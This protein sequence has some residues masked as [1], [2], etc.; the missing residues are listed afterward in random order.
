MRIIHLLPENSKFDAQTVRSAEAANCGENRF[1]RRGRKGRLKRGFCRLLGL[2][3]VGGYFDS[4]RQ[5]RDDLAWCQAIFIHWL[6]PKTVRELREL[7]DD[8]VIIW[9]CW[10]ADHY[11][12]VGNQAA[13]YLPDT[14]RLVD[15]LGERKWWRKSIGKIAKSQRGER[16][17][18][19][20]IEKGSATAD[21]LPGWFR[22]FAPRID[23]FCSILPEPPFTTRL[24]GYSAR[25]LREFPYYSEKDTLMPGPPRMAGEDVLLGNSADPSNNH[26]DAIDLLREIGIGDGKLVVPLNYGR[27]DVAQAVARCATE[28][29]GER[30]IILSDWLSIDAYNAVVSSC[31]TVVMN[32]LR[33]QAIGNISMALYKGAKV[34]LR[35]ENPLYAH[36]RNLGAEIFAIDDLS[37]SASIREPLSRE[38]RLRNKALMQEEWSERSIEKRV[39]QIIRAAECAG[40]RRARHDRA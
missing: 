20:G 21:R 18:D 33:A 8:K 39:G 12:L 9:C 6:Q 32:H 10:G 30:A 35:A 34:Y 29:F 36:Y 15:R 13:L 23:H 5:K 40:L 11:A 14:Q 28:A 37:G 17:G 3:I 27:R 25:R 26:L 19:A 24:P 38:A 22:K 16:P 2:P 31:G 4:A 7:P 1:R